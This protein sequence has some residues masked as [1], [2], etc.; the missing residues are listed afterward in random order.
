MVMCLNV[1][2]TLTW[3]LALARQAPAATTPN[4]I[5]SNFLMFIRSKFLVFWFGG[6]NPTTPSA[7]V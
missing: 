2:G 3:A 6:L 5:F 7:R 1:L 4:N